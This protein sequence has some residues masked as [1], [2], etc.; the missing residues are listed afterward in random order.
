[1]LIS[2]THSTVFMCYVSFF[3]IH[4]IFF[5]IFSILLLYFFYTLST[6]FYILVK[7]TVTP[8]A[9]CHWLLLFGYIY[10]VLSFHGCAVHWSMNSFIINPYYCLDKSL[11]SAHT[12]RACTRKP[13]GYT[14]IPCWVHNLSQMPC[15]SRCISAWGAWCVHAVA[16]HHSGW[17][18]R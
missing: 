10:I 1:M 14:V 12:D 6:F 8:Q 18:L 5:T 17:L 2:H 3:N 7:I 16:L 4:Y 13:L 15:H 9:C 11:P